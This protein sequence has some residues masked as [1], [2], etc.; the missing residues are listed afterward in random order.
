MYV[1]ILLLNYQIKIVAIAAIN[2]ENKIFAVKKEYKWWSVID[3]GET[4]VGGMTVGNFWNNHF[5]KDGRTYRYYAELFMPPADLMEWQEIRTIDKM[6]TVVD[7]NGNVFEGWE[8]KE[9]GGLEVLIKFAKLFGK[10]L[11]IDEVKVLIGAEK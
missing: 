4:K 6:V 1:L 3:C 8:D 7:A 10:S 11:T 2:M 9:D 5:K